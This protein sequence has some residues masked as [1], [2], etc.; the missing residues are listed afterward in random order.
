MFGREREIYVRC[1]DARL[2]LLKGCAIRIVDY[3]DSIYW[4]EPLEKG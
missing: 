4:I 1:R 3:D 2:A